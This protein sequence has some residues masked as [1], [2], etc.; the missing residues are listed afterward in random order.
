M[1]RWIGVTIAAAVLATIM[2]WLL[3]TIA[4]HT[5]DDFDAPERKVSPTSHMYEDEE[6]W[7]C[8]TQGNRRC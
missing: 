1:L 7:D 8:R 3:L 5:A 4:V 6:G 2:I